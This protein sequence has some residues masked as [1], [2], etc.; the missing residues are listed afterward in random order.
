MS[1]ID[2]KIVFLFQITENEGTGTKI[3]KY[4]LI[5]KVKIFI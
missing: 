3:L 4:Y 2:K 1:G 5:L